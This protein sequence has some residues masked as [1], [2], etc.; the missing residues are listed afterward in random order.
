MT[1]DAAVMSR[2]A[3]VV[4][5][6]MNSQRKSSALR[7]I[8]RPMQPTWSNQN[9]FVRNGR[10]GGLEHVVTVDTADLN[11]YTSPRKR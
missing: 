6:N 11:I 7:E 8:T 3:D 5:N 9:G 2:H 10:H 4:Y 1:Y